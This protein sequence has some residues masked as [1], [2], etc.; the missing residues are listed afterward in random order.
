M[1]GVCMTVY[2]YGVCM[3]VYFPSHVFCEPNHDNTFSPTSLLSDL[4]IK[5]LIGFRS[6][7]PHASDIPL[8]G[9]GASREGCSAPTLY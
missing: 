5:G 7:D 4:P 6:G 1:H 2:M 8:S 3:C 9:V